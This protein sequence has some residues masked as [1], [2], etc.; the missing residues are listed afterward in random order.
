MV[1]F[2]ERI[3]FSKQKTNCVVFIS[4]ADHTF[5]TGFQSLSPRWICRGWENS[6]HSKYGPL[7]SRSIW[8]FNLVSRFN[9]RRILNTRGE[10]WFCFPT[11]EPAAGRM[12]TSLVH[13][14]A[15]DISFH[16][17]M[18]FC[19]RSLGAFF[20]Q[21]NGVCRI[22]KS[23]LTQNPN[24]TFLAWLNLRLFETKWANS[25]ILHVVKLRS[26]QRVF[27]PNVALFFICL[28]VFPPF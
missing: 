2:T 8:N 12:C 16:K 5:S 11:L 23:L 19:L 26:Q 24:V 28:V 25:K 9:E 7:P 14:D 15:R 13:R 1:V 22:L 21:Q 27:M 18:T 10:R 4:Y 6:L 20:K 3:W 17:I